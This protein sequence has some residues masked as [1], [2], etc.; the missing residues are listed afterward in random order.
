MLVGHPPFDA[1]TI[2]HVLF[3]TLTAEAPPLRDQ[4]ADV[5]ERL[6][7]VVL[8]CLARAPSPRFQN[9]V[10]LAQALAPFSRPGDG[11]F[12]TMARRILRLSAQ[13][14]DLRATVPPEPVEDRPSD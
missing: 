8:R 6:E 14:E 3:K 13:R 2:G 11:R 7:Q 4:R 12:V 1:D 9:V 10:E 5:P